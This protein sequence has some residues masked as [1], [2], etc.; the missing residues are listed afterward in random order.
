MSRSVDA[1][2]FLLMLVPTS[3]QE[4]VTACHNSWYVDLHHIF[5]VEYV[6]MSSLPRLLVT[7][8]TITSLYIF[9]RGSQD[10]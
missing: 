5:V 1:A 10:H 2:T 6:G 3:C 8:R 9:S 7:T 4:A